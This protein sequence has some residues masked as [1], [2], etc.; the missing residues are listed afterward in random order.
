MSRVASLPLARSFEAAISAR[1]ESNL[2]NRAGFPILK[3]FEKFKVPQSSIPQPTLD[4]GKWRGSGFSIR[5]LLV[6]CR[7]LAVVV[8]A[9][10]MGGTLMKF[11]TTDDVDAV[12]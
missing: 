2:R 6:I 4:Y 8:P 1:D 5:L 9:V 12:V 11:R 10:P 7:F 3:S